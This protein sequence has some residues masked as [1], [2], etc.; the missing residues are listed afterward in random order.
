MNGTLKFN[1]GQISENQPFDW[2]KFLKCRLPLGTPVWRIRRTVMVTSN[3]EKVRYARGLCEQEAWDQVLA[4][5]QSWQ[6]EDP[7]DHR[8]GYLLWWVAEV[9]RT[10][11]FRGFLRELCGKIS[12]GPPLGDLRALAGVAASLSNLHFPPAPSLI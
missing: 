10:V 11:W 1:L 8:A 6:T 7:L 5:A 4:Y 12:P 2:L 3:D 9:C